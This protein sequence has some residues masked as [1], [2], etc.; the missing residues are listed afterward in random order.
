[1]V[2][3]IISVVILIILAW[4][5]FVPF[6]FCIDTTIDQ[7]YFEWSGIIKINFIPDKVEIFFIRVKIPFFHL[8]IYPVKKLID[9]EKEK[10]EKSGKEK[11]EKNLLQRINRKEV[12]KIKLLSKLGWKVFKALKLKKFDVN[13]DTGD[14]IYNAR[15]IPLFATLN[16]NRTNLRVNY[17]GIVSVVLL[18]EHS[19]FRILVILIKFLF[20][21]RKKLLKL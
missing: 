4:I 20:H 14:V 1:M 10:K 17:Q 16:G 11:S 18:F 6:R 3:L 15:L 5:L 13:I 8:H 21:N 19:V 12:R 7:Y 9:E 2:L